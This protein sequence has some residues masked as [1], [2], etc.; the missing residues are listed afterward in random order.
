MKTSGPERGEPLDE[1]PHLT[2]GDEFPV[3]AMLVDPRAPDP[4]KQAIQ[5]FDGPGTPTWWPTAM[6]HTI[7]SDIPSNWTIQLWEDGSLHL[8]PE[9]WLRPGFWEECFDG[10]P[11]AVTAFKREREV[12]LREAATS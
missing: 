11:E 4:W 8:A 3:L 2:V 9:D 10:N 7:S 1:H 12:I 6:F 5:V